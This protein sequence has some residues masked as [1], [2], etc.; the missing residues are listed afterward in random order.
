MPTVNALIRVVAGMFRGVFQTNAVQNA[1]VS[2]LKCKH[3]F[4]PREK[5]LGFRRMKF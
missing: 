2:R 4:K 1:E 3:F 5:Q